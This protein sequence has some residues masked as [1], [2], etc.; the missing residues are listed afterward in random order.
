MLFCVLK[1]TPYVRFKLPEI[2]PTAINQ[3]ARHLPYQ[4]ITVRAFGF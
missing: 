1:Q 4:Q 2:D 3:S